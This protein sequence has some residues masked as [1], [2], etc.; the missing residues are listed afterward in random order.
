MMAL[1]KVK[2]TMK[3]GAAIFILA[4]VAMNSAA[5]PLS[6]NHLFRITIIYLT[7]VIAYPFSDELTMNCWSG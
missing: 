1:S 3:S 2:N 5:K 6:I 7:K 4:A